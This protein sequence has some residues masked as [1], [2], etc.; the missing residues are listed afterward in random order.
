MAP[1][2]KLKSWCPYTWRGD[3]AK[4]YSDNLI[5]NANIL[6]SV[7]KFEITTEHANFWFEVLFFLQVG[8]SYVKCLKKEIVSASVITKLS[9]L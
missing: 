1:G 7:D 4:Y 2:K 8:C 3:N 6:K 5:Q 9:P